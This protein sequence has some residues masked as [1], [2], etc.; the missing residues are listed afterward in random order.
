MKHDVE[1][2]ELVEI[3]W[4]QI[5]HDNREARRKMLREIDNLIEN[6]PDEYKAPDE[7][8]LVTLRMFTKRC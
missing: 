8:T 3:L 7:N 5:G 6:I 1:F 2:A 4:F